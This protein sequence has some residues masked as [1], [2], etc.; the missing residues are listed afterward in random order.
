MNVHE[1]CTRTHLAADFN[2]LDI[3]LP[4]ANNSFVCGHGGQCSQA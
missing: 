3:M 4:N 2:V 1:R